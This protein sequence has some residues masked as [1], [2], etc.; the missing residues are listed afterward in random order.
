MNGLGELEKPP[1]LE[2]ASHH[3]HRSGRTTFL[4][5]AIGAVRTKPWLPPSALETD[6][7]LGVEAWGASL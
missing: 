3:H 2:T 6:P 1:Q 7:G 5:W 4:T